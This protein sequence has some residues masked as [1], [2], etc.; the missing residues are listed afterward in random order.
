MNRDELLDRANRWSQPRY[1]L[2]VTPRQLADWVH[3]A[4]VPGPARLKGTG[5]RV[6]QWEWSAKSYARVLRLC[7]AKGLGKK[8]GAMTFDALRI[9][10]WLQNADPISRDVRAAMGREYRRLIRRA[11]HP[12]RADPGPPLSPRSGQT[13]RV[14][15]VERPPD[16]RLRPVSDIIPPEVKAAFYDS[17]RFGI[18]FSPMILENIISKFFPSYTSENIPPSGI[19]LDLKGL[20]Q[21]REDKNDVAS[22]NSA[23][24]TIRNLD[25]RHFESARILLRKKRRAFFL[26]SRLIR[27]YAPNLAGIA[28]AFE[29]A[30]QAS[31]QFPWNFV[32]YVLFLHGLRKVPDIACLASTIDDVCDWALAG[33]FLHAP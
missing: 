14:R 19:C 30:G 27:H 32:S 18:E 4:L 6:P 22:P 12:H 21:L 20:A 33:G 26:I 16:E 11:F 10:I 9:V 31:L 5:T 29:V 28:S 15:A 2:R 8:Y 23:E 25:K 3:E 13:R 1:G 17:A 7:R 24:E